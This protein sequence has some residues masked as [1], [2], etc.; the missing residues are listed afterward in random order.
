[1]EKIKP[2]F[3]WTDILG[4]KAEPVARAHCTGK[5]L[6]FEILD[7]GK[8]VKVAERKNCQWV[9]RFSNVKV[10][11]AQAE[12]GTDCHVMEVETGESADVG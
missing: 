9:S 11:M 4:V 3:Q 2:K 12:D 8:W 6:Y 10:K 1:M 5:H 7:N